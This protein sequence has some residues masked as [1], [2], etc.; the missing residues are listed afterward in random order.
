MDEK[1]YRESK[2]K[3]ENFFNSLTK[4]D[5]IGIFLH[6]NC[7]DGTTSAIFLDEILRQKNLVPKILDFTM[8]KKEE[9]D[10]IWNLLESKEINKI[11]IADLSFDSIDVDLLNKIEEKYDLLFVDHHPKVDGLVDS[12]KIIKAD[13]VDC[14]SLLIWRL[15]EDLFNRDRIEWLLDSVMIYEFS[16][17]GDENL[18]FLMKRVP[19]FDIKTPIM[20]IPGQLMQK[21]SSVII[22]YSEDRVKSF[23]IIKNKDM[24]KIEEIH[25][26]VSKE[27]D[28]CMSDFEKNCENY[29]D[30]KLIWGNLNPKFRISS[31]ITTTLAVKHPE[32]SFAIISDE[33]DR[34]KV[35][36]R[37]NGGVHDL[38]KIVK[39]CIG[40]LENSNGGGHPKASGARVMK[41]D[42]ETFKKRLIE[43]CED[44]LKEN[45]QNI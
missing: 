30:A 31:A 20:C 10:K 37:S 27:F 16:Y 36:L 38:N 12:D 19:D 3:F 26:I 1:F 43:A 13:S 35:S 34:Y 44:Y 14:T 22:Y 2:K 33:G 18:E 45:P 4:E 24:E 42:I 25:K 23:E 17:N 15:G 41:K 40:G 21:L 11:I 7:L 5:K 32:K 8:Y 29:S 6:E 28:R 9:A 39:K